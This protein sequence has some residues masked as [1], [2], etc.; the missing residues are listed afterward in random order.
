MRHLVTNTDCRIGAL[1]L[2]SPQSYVNGQG[3]WSPFGR[4]GF[5]SRGEVPKVKLVP[6]LF[7]MEL[8]KFL[9]PKGHLQWIYRMVQLLN[10]AMEAQAMAYKGFPGGCGAP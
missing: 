9:K 7:R 10:V 2:G 4:L 8:V 5:N 3:P 6:K 1:P